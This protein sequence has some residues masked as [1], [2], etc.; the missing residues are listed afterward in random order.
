MA[1]SDPYKA[2]G[3]ARDASAEDIRRAYRK[4]AKKHHP[5]LNPG[6]K[7]AEDRF[8]SIS[9]AYELL[10]DSEKRGRFDRGEIDA[11]GQERPERHFYRGYAEGD[12]GAR[13][14]GGPGFGGGASF[15]EGDLGDI[16]GEFFGAR[17]RGGETIRMRG[18]DQQFRLTV[19]FLDTVRG[20][21]KRLALPEGRT[22]DVTIPPGV[23]DGQVLRLRGQGGPGVNGGPA[24]D[25]LIEIEVVPHPFFTRKG[26]DIH[27]ELPVSVAEAV[28][29]AKITV[30]TPSGSVTMSVPRHS[31]TGKQLRLRG[32]GIAA[33][34]GQPAGDLY[35][36]LKVVIGPVDAEFEE[37]LKTWSA[38]HQADPRREMAEQA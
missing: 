11:S 29:G 24:G 19:D 10:S 36:T 6:D 28:L 18:R 38:K 9:A 17:G 21:T 1:E 37:F 26:N 14:H 4:L 7:A 33:H 34:G 15:T 13:Y 23:Q 3:V 2:L 16:F 5:D 22:L 31:D 12:Q 27:L 25:A 30:P 32:R 8:K 20:A 35:V